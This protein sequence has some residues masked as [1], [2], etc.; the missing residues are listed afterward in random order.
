M[1]DPAIAPDE[2]FT[3]RHY[4]TWPEEERWELIGGQA[5]AMS[6]APATRHQQL[7]GRLY[8]WLGN[9]LEGRPCQV[10]IA[11]FDVLL[12]AGEEAD[13]E[14]DTL[15]Q[16]DILVYCEP[17]RVTPRSGR[18]APDLVVEVLTKRTASR[19]FGVK[20]RLYDRHGVREYWIVD[21][22]EK[23]IHAWRAREKGGFGEE[24]ILEEGESL[25]SSVVEGFSLD[26]AKLYAD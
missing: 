19:D 24:E 5:F 25:A 20:W 6:P 3:Y 4:R 11:P 16:P 14:V 12:P 8:R 22:A 21:A 2:R 26:L 13:D 17:S 1:G 9:H 15:V 10:F 7:T 23:V 18:G